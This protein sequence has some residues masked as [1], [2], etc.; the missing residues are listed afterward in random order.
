MDFG[1]AEDAQQQPPLIQQSYSS[2]R[3]AFE[4]LLDGATGRLE[5]QGL[6]QVRAPPSPPNPGEFRVHLRRRSQPALRC[7]SCGGSWPK[8]WSSRPRRRTRC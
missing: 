8:C 3:N 4:R 5:Q 6:A 2:I 1:Q 7:V